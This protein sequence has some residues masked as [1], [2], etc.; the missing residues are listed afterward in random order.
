MFEVIGS[1]LKKDMLHSCSKPFTPEAIGLCCQVKL[2]MDN[3]TGNTWRHQHGKWRAV[4]DC[5]CNFLHA[6]Y[7]GIG[8]LAV[9]VE[10]KD[11]SDWQEITKLQ[12][13]TGRL[14]V[15]FCEVHSRVREALGMTRMQALTT[16]VVLANE[17]KNVVTRA[18]ESSQG[19]R[20][21]H[22]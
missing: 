4:L 15:V 20:T 14:L 22:D 21:F 8:Q 19:L 13:K 12:L 9:Y 7:D 16:Q 6:P 10:R 11:L 17:N 5:T 18:V 1:C 3:D 2:K